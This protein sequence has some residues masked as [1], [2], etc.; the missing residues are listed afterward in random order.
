MRSL[1]RIFHELL[2][3]DHEDGRATWQPQG[4]VRGVPEWYV[5]GADT[6]GRQEGRPYPRS[7]QVIHEISGLGS[8]S[9]LQGE[10][11]KVPELKGE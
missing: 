7:Q 5:A 11:K 4:V 3:R 6:R 1:A 9:Y 10:I 2:S 8:Q